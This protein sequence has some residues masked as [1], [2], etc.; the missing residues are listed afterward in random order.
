MASMSRFVLQDC[1]VRNHEA[2]YRPIISSLV[3][4]RQMQ[5]HLDVTGRVSFLQMPG[6]CLSI[7][8]KAVAT[9][10][11]PNS[12]RLPSRGSLILCKSTSDFSEDVLGSSSR[13]LS[14]YEKIIETLTTLFPVWVILGTIVGIYKPAAVMYHFSLLQQ[15]NDEKRVRAMSL[16]WVSAAGYVVRNESVHSWFGFP[17]AFYGLDIEV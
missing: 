14:Q 1:G 7:R 5:S 3:S 6:S 15:S 9:L 12:R 10:S 17:H 13:G 2:L 16:L 4:S 8:S 11:A